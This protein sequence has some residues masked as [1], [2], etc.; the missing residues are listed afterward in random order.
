MVPG[1]KSILL[2]LLLPPDHFIVGVNSKLKPNLLLYST[3][4][5]TGNPMLVPSLKLGVIAFLFAV[6]SGTIKLKY[7]TVLGYVVALAS[8]SWYDRLFAVSVAAIWAFAHVIDKMKTVASTNPL[9]ST[10]V[11]SF[12]FIKTIIGMNY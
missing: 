1:S 8:R 3:L 7:P 4:T 2:V 12:L 5:P 6:A 11:S 9:C 10:G